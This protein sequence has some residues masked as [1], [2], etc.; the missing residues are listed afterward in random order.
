MS[1]PLSFLSAEQ[2]ERV[3]AE[4][5]RSKS[6]GRRDCTVLLLLARL[7]LRAGEVVTLELDDIRWR[8]GEIVIRG[9]GRMLDHL[10]LIR[11][12]GEALTYARPYSNHVSM[13]A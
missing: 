2:T 4:V 3:L 8:S 7:G 1:T 13:A 10:P 6:T 11:D 5:D 9:K 12:V